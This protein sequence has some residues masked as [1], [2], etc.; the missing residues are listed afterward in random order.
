MKI[1]MEKRNKFQITTNAVEKRAR[2]R[3]KKGISERTEGKNRVHCE[4]R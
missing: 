4:W 2:E 3:E 1:L